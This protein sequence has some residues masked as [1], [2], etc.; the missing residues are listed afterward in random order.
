[1]A[2]AP[3]TIQIFH[4]TLSRGGGMERY[5]T[6]LASSFKALGWEVAFHP[7][8]YEAELGRALDAKVVPVKVA[9]FPRKLQDYRYYRAVERSRDEAADLQVALWRVR[10]R[11]LAVCGGTHRGY[12]E[13][14]R[15][16]AGPFDW[17]QIWMERRAYAFARR[18]I[19]HSRLCTD[20]LIAR[21]GVSPEKV[22]TLF[23]PV[24]GRFTSECDPGRRAAIRKRLGLPEDKVVFLF[25]SMGH[26][27]KGLKPIREALESFADQAVL[28]VAG[29]GPVRVQDG[30]IRWLG[31]VEEMT[32]AYQAADFTI[33]GSYYEPFG[34]V[35]P[36]SILC[37]TRLVFEER[38]GCLA[39][40]KPGAAFT[41]SVWDPASIRGAIAEAIA[42]ARIGKH[43][44]EKPAEAL[45]Y[46]PA[47]L[48]HA[49]ALIAAAH[50]KV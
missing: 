36:E 33:L 7:H 38:I 9:R 2:E 19:S 25:P 22:V 27:R 49:R 1:M 5:A 43:R 20:E 3:R 13:Q 6:T 12:L 11:D 40:V 46:D 32:Q 28:A 48:E 15:K 29:K 17:L 18:I 24:D 21:Y 50:L 44:I 37:G 16:V 34:L 8:R 45:A 4:P 14:A 47:P 41:F 10:A 42:L 35:G 39:A 23:P 31:Y 26:G 30:L